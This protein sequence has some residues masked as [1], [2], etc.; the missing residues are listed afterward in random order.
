MIRQ[1]VSQPKIKEAIQFDGTWKC[2]DTIIEWMGIDL[3]SQYGINKIETDISTGQ[4][5]PVEIIIPTI[6]I[7]GVVVYKDDYIVKQDI[8]DFY[9]VKQ[10]VFEST[11][12][13]RK[14]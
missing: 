6:H 12:S 7:D 2:Y 3:Y 1:Y 14:P 10:E 4:D 8:N 13:L 5:I 9:P 11:Y